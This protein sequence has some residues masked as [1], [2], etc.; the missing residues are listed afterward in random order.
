MK[1]MSANDFNTSDDKFIEIFSEDFNECCPIHKMC[2]DKTKKSKPWIS[3]GLKYACKK[4]SR[5]I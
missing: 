3:T 1:L 2:L 4:K 5:Y